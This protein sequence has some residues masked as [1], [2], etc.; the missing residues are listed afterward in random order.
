VCSNLIAFLFII[1]S[2]IGVII[3]SSLD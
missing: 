3:G 1:P 2:R